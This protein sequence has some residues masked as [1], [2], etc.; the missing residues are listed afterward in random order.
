MSPLVP[1]PCPAWCEREHADVY[2][3]QHRAEVGHLDVQGKRLFVIVVQTLDRPATVM[4]SGEELLIIEEDQTADA[5]GVFTLLGWPFLAQL[6][7]RAAFIVER[8][9]GAAR[10]AEAERELAGW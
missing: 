2:G 10:R 5:R 4:I 1:G 7:E 9:N 8:F 6:I 3:A